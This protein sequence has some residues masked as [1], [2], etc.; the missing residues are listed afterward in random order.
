MIF[1]RRHHFI[2]LANR[3]TASTSIA[4][5]LS[6]VCGPSDVIAPLGK[7]EQFRTAAGFR[8]PQHFIPWNQKPLYYGLRIQRKLTGRS[9]DRELRRIGFHTHMTAA[10]AIQLT[11]EQSWDQAFKFCFIRNPWDRAIS[12][13]FW[14]IR[15]HPDPI[16][17]DAFIDGDALTR[18]AQR[19]R[20]IYTIDNAIAVDR[21]CRFEAI[22]DE[23]E[24]IYR[25][26]SIPF[27]PTLPKAKTQY[28][29]D[30]R[31]YRDVLNQD[32]ATRIANIFAEEIELGR[33]TY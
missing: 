13:Y 31:H 19:S 16:S 30:R 2:F 11:G 26:L 6:E 29:Q 32:Q 15:D 27:K 5:A 12:Q 4:I 22:N 1:S 21:L 3:K 25:E 33:Y 14:E 23:L 28:R 10:Q 9:I 7:D 18:A 20:E 24:T 17:L 8:A